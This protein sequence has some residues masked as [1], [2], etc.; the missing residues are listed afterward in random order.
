M[1]ITKE[2]SPRTPDYITG[3]SVKP[4]LID[5]FGN[6]SFTDGTTQISP[7]QQQCEAYGYTYDAATSTCF[8]YRSN[9]NLRKAFNNMDNKLQGARNNAEAGATRNYVVGHNNNVKS[10]SSDNLIVGS[11]NE[12]GVNIKNTTVLGNYGIA[13]RPGEFVIGGG[14][15]TIG[16]G[17]NSTIH[18]SGVTENEAPTNLLVNGITSLTTIARDSDTS[19]TSFTGFEAN[20]MG[21]RTGGTAAGSVY[22]RILLRATGI[23]YLKAD[24]QS[25]T[26]LGS[27]GTVAGWTAAVAFSGTNDMHLEVTGSRDMEIAWS[28]TLN[29]YEMKV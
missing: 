5:T 16:K 14:G 25:V 20:V 10:Q 4:S 17:Q 12:V 8:A 21:V 11:N 24:N 2:E 3:Y 29:L 22:D 15:N 26:T 28:C 7:T 23:A 6:V 18:L 13:Q 9:P 1:S 19:S 27:F